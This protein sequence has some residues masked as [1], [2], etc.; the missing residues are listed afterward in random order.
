MNGAVTARQPASI[1]AAAGQTQHDGYHGPGLHSFAH[2]VTSSSDAGE[3][4]ENTIPEPGV[5]ISMDTAVTVTTPGIRLTY[6]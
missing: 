6:N 5:V 3:S 4:S 2:P 1:K